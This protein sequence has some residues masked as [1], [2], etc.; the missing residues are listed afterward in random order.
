[1][2]WVADDVGIIHCTNVANEL[3]AQA[4]KR[5]QLDFILDVRFI[6]QLWLTSKWST[7]KDNERFFVHP[8]HIHCQHGIVPVNL[9][10]NGSLRCNV[11][12]NKLRE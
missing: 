5:V 10:S 12:Y 1:M 6:L 2:W 11:M 7:I 8:A 9:S 4:G 3:D